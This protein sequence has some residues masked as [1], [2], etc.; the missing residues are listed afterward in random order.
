MQQ[1]LGAAPEHAHVLHLHVEVEVAADELGVAVLV[2]LVGVERAQ[3][4][5][6]DGQVVLDE[7][8]GVDDQL[9]EVLAQ[10]LP[11]EGEPPEVVDLQVAEHGHHQ[12]GG[13]TQLVVAAQ[14]GLDELLGQVGVLGLENIKLHF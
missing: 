10:E 11:G 6:E 9:V 1:R 4:R 7:G 12:L 2:L 13:L 5:D 3:L 8:V 14:Q